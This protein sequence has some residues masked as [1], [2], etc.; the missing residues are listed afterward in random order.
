[1]NIKNIINEEIVSLNETT[2]E[3]YHGTN[4]KFSNFSF[5][6]A[7]QG[8]VWFTNS[9]DTIRNQEHGGLGS[10]HIIKRYITINNPAGWDEYEKYSLGEIDNMGY[11]GI[12]LPDSGDVINFIMFNRNGISAKPSGDVISI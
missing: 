6:K 3:V 10:K 7:T 12:I 4:E 1:M 9:I 11:D 8:V 5:T 2:Y